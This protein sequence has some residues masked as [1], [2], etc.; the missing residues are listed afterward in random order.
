MP[1]NGTYYKEGSVI[2][3]AQVIAATSSTS[4]T[5]S[6]YFTRLDPSTTYNVFAFGY[7]AKCLDGRY[8]TP[9]IHTVPL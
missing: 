4:F 9:T 5:T 6:K 7:N 2:G 1:A 8:T 3:N